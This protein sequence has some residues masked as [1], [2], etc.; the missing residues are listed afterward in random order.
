MRGPPRR[1]QLDEA[2]LRA[3]A[4]EVTGGLGDFGGPEGDWGFHKLVR[5]V[6]RGEVQEMPRHADQELAARVLV[7]WAATRLHFVNDEK[8]YPQILEEKI[9]KPVVVM[10]IARS[11][12]TLLQSLLAADP[13]HRGLHVWELRYPSP[14]PALRESP[15]EAIAWATAHMRANYERNRSRALVA[16]PYYDEGGMMLAE[17]EWIWSSPVYLMGMRPEPIQ[18][19]AFH[20]RF[21]QHIQHRSAPRRWVL[22]GVS[23]QFQIGGVLSTYPDAVLV[24]IHRDPVKNI[25]SYLAYTFDGPRRPKGDR[26]AEARK[27]VD[28]LLSDLATAM[29]HPH[30]DRVHHVL[31]SDLLADPADTLRAVY[32]RG[33]LGWTAQTEAAVRAWLDDPAHRA[34]RHGRHSYSLGD[35]GLTAA[36]IDAAFAHYRQRFGIPHEGAARG[37]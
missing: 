8:L 35:F 24:W 5:R 12:T 31:Y 2:A 11:G 19:Y 16:H 1:F 32:E 9:D 17:C 29:S 6:E 37:A 10:G 34:D 13:A 7:E 4:A 15:E 14:P 18:R 21:L 33:G 3:R 30:L 36:E 20:R 27:M 23:H 28:E 25:A 26:F 22:K